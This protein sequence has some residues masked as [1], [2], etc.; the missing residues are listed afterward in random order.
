MK[1][2]GPEQS[3][4]YS[5]VTSGSAI[6]IN[7]EEA[8]EVLEKTIVNVALKDVRDLNGNVDPTVYRWECV[9]RPQSVEMGRKR[10]RD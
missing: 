7:L 4:K 2:K 5:F 1:S 3:I 10:S 9:C 8:P 6:I